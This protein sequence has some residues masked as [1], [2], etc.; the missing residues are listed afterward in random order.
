MLMS[1]GMEPP[2]MVF[3]HGWWTV[4]GK[5]MS[6]SLHNFVEPTYI[7]DK[8]SV[9]ALRYFL[10]REMPLGEDGD[11]SEESLKARING[12][13]V[14]DLGNLVYR[15]LTLAERFEGSIDGSPELES[16]LDVVKI[17]ESMEKVDPFGA[18]NEIWSFVRS[19]NKYV[20]DNQVWS[21]K[22]E[23]LSNALYNLLEACRVCPYCFTRSCPRRRRGSASSSAPV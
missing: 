16:I 13:L 4:N 17:D 1:A 9:D 10:I 2:K 20:N 19:S 18:L 14:A 7:T 3:A 8:Y 12:E 21:L 11:F 23:Q 22:G 15:V 6:K 5:K